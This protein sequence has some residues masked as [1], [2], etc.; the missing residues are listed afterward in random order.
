MITQEQAESM[1][2]A[3]RRIAERYD[4]P[5]GIRESSQDTYG[6]EYEEALEMA[7]DNIQAEAAHAIKGISLTP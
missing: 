5:E 1:Y 4:S 2:R 7:Y 3:L 6:L